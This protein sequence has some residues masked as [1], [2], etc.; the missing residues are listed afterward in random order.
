MFIT[1]EC[2][3]LWPDKTPTICCSA[4]MGLHTVLLYI[5]MTVECVEQAFVHM[6]HKTLH[7][8]FTCT[9]IQLLEPGNGLVLP[10]WFYVEVSSIT[11]GQ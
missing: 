11:V 6:V 1:I 9:I 3:P 5:V 8:L 10:E 4:Y 7:L 2:V